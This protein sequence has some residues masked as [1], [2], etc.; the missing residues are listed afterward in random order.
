MRS[1]SHKLVFFEGGTD[2]LGVLLPNHAKNFLRNGNSFK[3]SY[4]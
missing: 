2:A 1:K 4:C 3:T